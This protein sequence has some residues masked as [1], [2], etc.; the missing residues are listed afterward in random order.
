MCRSCIQGEDKFAVNAK[1]TPV[2]DQP[3][4]GRYNVYADDVCDL[5]P[6]SVGQHPLNKA[7]D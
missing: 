4:F 3:Y 6:G 7:R 2:S 5:Y 1:G